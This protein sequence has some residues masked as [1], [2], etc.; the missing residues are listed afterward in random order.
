MPKILQLLTQEGL[1]CLSCEAF[2][3]DRDRFRYYR[4]GDENPAEMPFEDPQLPRGRKALQE[5]PHDV[6]PLFS[7]Y[8]DGSRRTY[9]VG[10]VIVDK[11]RYYPLVAGQVGVAVVTRQPD[12][13]IK[14]LRRFCAISN[15]LAIPDEIADD[16]RRL[17]EDRIA[18]QLDVP[19][20]LLRYKVDP[21]KDAVDLAVA[22]I[23]SKMHDEEIRIVKDMAAANLLSSTRMLV[24]DGPLRFRKRFD[25]IQFKNVIGLSKR[26]RP[27][28]TV[29]KGR[30]RVGVG[31]I[32]GSSG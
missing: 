16:D 15:V 18:S 28:F 1:D 5:A 29:G 24:I 13:R 7:Y 11:K 20:D 23:M 12:T 30:K 26:F 31:T 3:L 9:R 21:S 2:S 25:I 27:T 4:D 32:T 17:F 19:F 14:P 22:K 8:L 10:D 6:P